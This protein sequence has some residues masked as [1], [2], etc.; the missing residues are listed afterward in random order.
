MSEAR[1]IVVLPAVEDEPIDDIV[2]RYSNLRSLLRIGVLIRRFAENCHR[3][4][5]RLEPLVGPLTAVEIDQTLLALVRRTQMQHF[6]KD[7]HQLSTTAQVDRKSRLRYLHPQLVDDLIRVGGRLHNA[8]IPIEEKHPIVLPAKCHL[9]EMIA[10]KE[11]QK[12]LHA[13]PGLLLSSLRQRFWPLGGRNLVRQI[14]HRCITCVRAKPKPLEQ[15]M[16]QLPP[17]RVNQ[18]HPFQNVGIDLAGPIYVR[19]SLRNKRNPFFKA[20]IVVY[21][22][23]ATKAAHL[24]LVSDLTS[25]AFIASLRRFTGRRGKPAHIYC[26][27]ATN[28][29]GA[30][31]ELDELRKL[32]LSQQHKQRVTQEVTEDGIQFIPPRSPS[33]GGI[34]E[35]CVKSVKNLLRKIMGNA[36]LTECELQTALIQVEAML[37]S[38]PITPLPN[39]PNEELALTP[40][41]FLVGRPLNMMPDPDKQQVPESSLSR[42]KRVQKLSLHFWSRWHQD[43][44]ATLQNLYRWNRALDKLAVGS[45]VVLKEENITPQ[46]WPLGRVISIH[47]GSD[48]RVRV[49]TVRTSTGTTKRAI[50]KLCVEFNPN[51]PRNQEVYSWKPILSS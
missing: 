28:F 43:Y 27:N 20:Y 25:E 2:Y 9:T 32:F 21:V 37:N 22:C 17:V 7:I 6:A 44:L 42:W 41:H 10:S 18:A 33:F 1:K 46:K 4:K 12:T 5:N 35:A 40:G 14:V 50:N 11:H 39:D 36:H 26:D 48:G 3:H 19:T 8:Q 29:V 16:G 13:G 38:R 34:W 45:I 31:R 51:H 23:L 47:P 24:E 49:A 15:L 30:K